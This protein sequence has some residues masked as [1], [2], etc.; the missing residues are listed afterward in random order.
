MALT[1]KK[2][3]ASAFGA[4]VLLA[5]ISLFLS[6]RAL[7]QS[8]YRFSSFVN[9]HSKL[10]STAMDV[11]SAVNERAIAARNLVL[12][13]TQA[14][15]D[16]EYAAVVKAHEHVGASLKELQAL[17]KEDEH[18]TD[19]D[20]AYLDGISKVESLYGPVALAIVK[21][22]VDGEREAAVEMMNKECRPL[23]AQL[24]GV[25][26]DYVEYSDT[27]AAEAVTEAHS[28]YVM[29][30]NILLSGG[31]L[32]ALC[33]IALGILL[34]RS[35][36]GALGAEP[37]V[38]RDVVSRVADGDLSPVTGASQAKQGSVLSSLGQMQT[39]LIGLIGQVHSSAD[40]IAS[41]SNQ[42]ADDNKNLSVRTTQQA[43]SLQETATSMSNLGETVKQNAS[44]SQQA[45]ELAQ[46]AAVVAQK[47]GAV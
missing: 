5:L 36:F 11:R 33:A 35:I 42:I 29:N 30:R 46:G 10:V 18:A 23:L 27:Q 47:G 37:V 41:A 22:A 38:L 16:L 44:D 1:L 17:V 28:T 20:I 45:N 8:D 34:I 32:A 39:Q 3:L 9:E 19:R 7:S 4:M 12:V 13:T 6:V 40:N 24:L 14:D 31:A 15:K 2:Q 43:S 21:L 25:V 26:A